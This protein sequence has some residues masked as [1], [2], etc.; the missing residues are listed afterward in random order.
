MEEISITKKKKKKRKVRISL[1]PNSHQPNLSLNIISTLVNEVNVL[2][3]I[4]KL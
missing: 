2:S 1:L 3:K 4:R